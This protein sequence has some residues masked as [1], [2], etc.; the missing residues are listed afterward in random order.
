MDLI[1]SLLYHLQC[2]LLF[3]AV[4]LLEE[5]CHGQA[6][7]HASSYIQQADRQGESMVATNHRQERWVILLSNQALHVTHFH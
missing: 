5:G 7:Q 3:K 4:L 6:E 2:Q 1:V